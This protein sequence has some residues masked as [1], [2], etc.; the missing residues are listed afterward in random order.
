MA[1][2]KKKPEP[3]PR[4]LAEAHEFVQ[5]TRPASDASPAVWLA[6]R[7]AN[8]RLYDHI[9]DVDRGH[10]H[11]SKYYVGYEQRKAE[12]IAAQIQEEDQADN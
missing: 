4:T 9:A 6:Y 11:E 12:E 10:H 8:A 5:R 3:E 2:S 1:T 7:R